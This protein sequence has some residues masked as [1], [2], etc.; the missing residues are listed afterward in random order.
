MG[1][2]VNVTNSNQ[3]NTTQNVSQNMSH[4]NR[5]IVI[6]TKGACIGFNKKTKMGKIGIGYIIDFGNK[7]KYRYIET[8]G[9]STEIVAG[10]NAIIFPLR[11]L[12]NKNTKADKVIIESDS[13]I[14]I[15][16]ITGKQIIKKDNPI[17]KYIKKIEELLDQIAELGNIENI[18]FQWVSS[19]QNKEIRKFVTKILRVSCLPKYKYHNKEICVKKFI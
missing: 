19:N 7:H 18:E 5:T 17:K 2:N 3:V 12:I 10:Y 15:N 6:H 13:Q 4:T 1:T 16:Q 8:L 11:Y 9:Y 14:I